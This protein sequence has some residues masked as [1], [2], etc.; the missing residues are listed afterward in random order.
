MPSS[1]PCPSGRTLTGGPRRP[2]PLARR[3]SPERNPSN[4]PLCERSPCLHW[5]VAPTPLIALS[6]VA[7]GAWSASGTRQLNGDSPHPHGTGP[8]GRGSDPK[9]RSPTPGST[10]RR[11][12]PALRHSGGAPLPFDWSIKQL[13]LEISLRQRMDHGAPSEARG[14]TLRTVESQ[15]TTREAAAPHQTQPR[16]A[17]EMA[18]GSPHAPPQPGPPTVTNVAAGVDNESDL[19]RVDETAARGA[20]LRVP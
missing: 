5:T 10:R 9:D 19:E 16:E 20:C 15:D 11:G 14:S 8:K 2:P 17:G 3:P 4:L 18:R 1:L 12:A 7:T 13:K 6:T